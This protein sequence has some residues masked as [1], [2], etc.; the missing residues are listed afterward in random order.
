M[1]LKSLNVIAFVR[2]SLVLGTGNYETA[3]KSIRDKLCA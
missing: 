3:F 1:P 2:M